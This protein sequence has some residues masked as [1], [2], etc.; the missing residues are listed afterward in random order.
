MKTAKK[1]LKL[2]ALYQ[3][4]NAW[5]LIVSKRSEE[6]GSEWGSFIDDNDDAV[7]VYAKTKNKQCALA[8]ELLHFAIQKSGYR[9][10]RVSTT[11]L[12][13]APMKRLVDCLDNELQHHHMF[14]QYCDLGYPPK[15]FYND[16]DGEIAGYLEEAL[17]ANKNDLLELIPDYM[18]LIA[19]GG[20]LTKKEKQ[21]L[22]SKFRA[23]TSDP[24]VFDAIDEAIKK[25][26]KLD[27][28]NQ[29]SIVSSIISTI[30]GEHSTWIGFDNGA[31]FPDSGFFVGK[32]LTKE[33]FAQYMGLNRT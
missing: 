15:N 10:M 27:S 21:A 1:N 2:Y 17:K 32:P 26:I 14:S 6:D 20:S 29:E 4:I 22:S 31:G 16:E 25:W 33:E 18:T 23:S 3:E 7:V 24:E 19:P 9:R 5:K 28:L 11:T 8:H 30:P 12:K 13:T